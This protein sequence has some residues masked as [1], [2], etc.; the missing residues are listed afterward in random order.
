VIYEGSDIYRSGDGRR[1]A[2]TGH[3]WL[4]KTDSPHRTRHIT[5]GAPVLPGP[6]RELSIQAPEEERQ[7][8]QRSHCLELRKV[9]RIAV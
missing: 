9:N 6:M 4:S 7:D 8:T 1:V 3:G 2:Q 5:L